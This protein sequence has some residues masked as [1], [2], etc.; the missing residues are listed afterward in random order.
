MKTLGSFFSLKGRSMKFVCRDSARPFLVGFYFWYFS[1]SCL[2]GLTLSFGGSFFYFSCSAFSI[3]LLTIQT[4]FML[5]N[6]SA[7][8]TNF[9]TS[10]N[11]SRALTRSVLNTFFF[12]Y[13]CYLECQNNCWFMTYIHLIGCLSE[14]LDKPKKGLALGLLPKEESGDIFLLWSIM[15]KSHYKKILI[16]ASRR[17]PI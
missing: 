2:G 15:L 12:C 7:C 8:L 5:P 14:L 1:L 9:S 10:C 13:Q 4:K 16:F 6:F 11:N 17:S 3:V